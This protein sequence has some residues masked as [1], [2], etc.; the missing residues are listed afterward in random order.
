MQS[1]PASVMPQAPNDGTNQITCV[2]WVKV[3]DEYIAF[4]SDGSD[5]SSKQHEL[6]WI[7]A[8]KV[9]ILGR[10]YNVV[11][12]PAFNDYQSDASVPADVPAP[13]PVAD[14]E[15]SVQVTVIGQRQPLP[16]TPVA[17]PAGRTGGQ[18]SENQLRR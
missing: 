11:T 17:F 14:T 5:Y 4:L 18:F 13:V 10:V 7:T 9:S 1:A 8:R 3:N 15:N 2:G 16:Q 6:D 12:R